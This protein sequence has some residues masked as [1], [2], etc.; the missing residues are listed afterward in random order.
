MLHEINISETAMCITVSFHKSLKFV[1]RR[2][3][4]AIITTTAKANSLRPIFSNSSAKTAFWR[5]SCT[6]SESRTAGP[7]D[8]FRVRGETGSQGSK[9]LVNNGRGFKPGVIPL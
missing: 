1:Q 8:V 3:V 4:A 5:R 9:C 7:K 2:L 6:S